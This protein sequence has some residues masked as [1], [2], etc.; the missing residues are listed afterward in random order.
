MR[1]PVRTP[2]RPTPTLTPTPTPMPTPTPVPTATP[3]P[4]PT[5]TPTPVPTATPKPRPTPK[6]CRYRRCRTSV[7]AKA[8]RLTASAVTTTVRC[9]KGGKPCVRTVR[10][11]LPAGG[12][13][14]ETGRTTVKVA[15]GRSQR[16]KVK[17]DARGRAEL[18]GG[19]SLLIRVG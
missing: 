12:K 5:A 6:P 8:T 11:L 10:A 1:T 17:L 13:R 14:V 19:G 9:P 3:T 7:A 2:V 16:V 18:A 4:V 15:P